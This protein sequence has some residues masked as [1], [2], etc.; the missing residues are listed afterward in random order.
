MTCKDCRY[1]AKLSDHVAFACTSLRSTRGV[2][3]GVES[4]CDQF[5]MSELA[6]IDP[7]PS[8][9]IVQHESKLSVIV[10]LID[11]GHD[12][13]LFMYKGDFFVPTVVHASYYSIDDIKAY[14]KD[15]KA[16]PIEVVS[17]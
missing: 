14:L 15:E 9:K 2:I 7:K 17:E 1:C 6:M 4:T 10:D 3:I 12:I 5:E 13:L 16:I 8:H 11:K